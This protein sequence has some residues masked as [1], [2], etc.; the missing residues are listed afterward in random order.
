MEPDCVCGRAA[1]DSTGGYAFAYITAF[2]DGALPAELGG[3]EFCA[4]ARE[5]SARERL[6]RAVTYTGP[7][8][9]VVL[10]GGLAGL[11]AADA[12]SEALAEYPG[13]LPRG[14]SLTLIEGERAMGGR[15]I[16]APIDEQRDLHPNA[17]YRAHVPHG[18]HFVWGCYEHFL[19]FAHGAGPA[20]VPDRGTSTY[21]AWLAPPDLAQGDAARVV[22]LHVCNPEIPEQAWSPRARS[23]LRA[24]ARSSRAVAVV[25]QML[26]SLFNRSIALHDYLSYLDILFAEE[27]LGPELRWRIFAAGVFASVARLAETSTLLREAL[28]G[29]DP[30]EVDIGELMQPTFPGFAPTLRR[31]P[32]RRAVRVGGDD[33]AHMAPLADDDI[34]GVS[35]RLRDD[36]RA[37]SGVAGLLARDA[38]R[39][40]R[41]LGRFHP[42]LRGKPEISGRRL[43]P[44]HDGSGFGG[45][46]PPGTPTPASGASR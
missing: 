26:G 19:R 38:T 8:N 25:E 43:R 11:A 34:L 7:L 36:A 16:S 27:D 44:W 6:Y 41:R 32:Q 46:T 21:C 3:C 12:I 13:E 31:T 40:A 20:L 4:G 37:V 15:A 33:S 18:I 30:T 24:V 17:P 42:K 10:G 9:I 35:G 14:M 22:A 45:S 39:V 2:T 29:R 5:R 1:V 28:D 23:V